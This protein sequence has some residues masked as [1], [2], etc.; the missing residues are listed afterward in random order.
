[1]RTLFLDAIAW[2]D[3]PEC[4][5]AARFGHKAATLGRWSAEFRV[6]PGFCLAAGA[7]ADG[8]LPPELARAVAGA[9]ERLG[10]GGAD[11]PVAVRSSAPGEDGE[12]ASFAGQHETLLN[13]VGAAEVVDA[14][15]RCLLSARS[16]RAVAYRRDRAPVPG[17]PR[18]AV[19]VQRMVPADASAV[20]FTADPVTGEHGAV[21]VEAA[22]GLGESLAGGTVTPDGWRVRKDGLV[23]VDRRPGHKRRMTVS[24]PGGTREVDVPRLLRDR[25]AL[26]DDQVVAVARLAVRLER[27]EAR[28]VDVECAFDG[29]DLYLLQC[30]PVTGAATEIKPLRENADV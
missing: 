15:R 6:P 27:R 8:V 11:P 23:V 10:G 21:L 30:R 20:A 7:T 5:D 17:P 24:A 14:V 4:R 29:E 16:L 9:Y 18:M 22:W 19:L 1:M 13:R 28:P 26:R 3:G 2:L 25:P 12:E